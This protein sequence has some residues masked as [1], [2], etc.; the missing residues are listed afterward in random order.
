MLFLFD[1]IET[2]SPIWLGCSPILRLLSLIKLEI[3]ASNLHIFANP[4]FHFWFLK[5]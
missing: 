1:R 2:K 5:H 3:N 4:L